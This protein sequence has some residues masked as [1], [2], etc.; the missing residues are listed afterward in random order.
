[1]KRRSDFRT[2]CRICGRELT[3]AFQW[4]GYRYK[5]SKVVALHVGKELPEHTI[6]CDEPKGSLRR[7]VIRR[8]EKECFKKWGTYKQT[9]TLELAEDLVRYNCGYTLGQLA[10]MEDAEFF[11][12]YVSIMQAKLLEATL[13]ALDKMTK[14]E[15][16]GM[17]NG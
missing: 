11:D 1:M 5:R 4:K 6:A 17:T 8:L 7:I 12:F 14:K 9:K 13:E 10:Q 2:H 3:F 16:Y 15:V